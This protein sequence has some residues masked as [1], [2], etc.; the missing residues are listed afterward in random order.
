MEKAY[1]AIKSY[2]K[3]QPYKGVDETSWRDRGLTHYIWVASTDDA[4]CFSISRRRNRLAFHNFLEEASYGITTDR[5]SVYRSH[6]GPHQYCLAHILRDFQRIADRNGDEGEIGQE[7]VFH[8]RE[9]FKLSKDNPLISKWQKQRIH[10]RR[11]FIKRLLTE[12]LFYEESPH[13]VRFCQRLLDDYDR[14]WTFLS[15][16]ELECHNNRSERDL[17]SLVLWRKKSFGTQ[18][19]LGQEFVERIASVCG[20]LKKRKQ[21]LLSFISKSFRA[22]LFGEKFP[23]PVVY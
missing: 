5:Y 22:S 10:Y 17:R 15:H 9:V 20:T 11:R 7:L 13:L 2:L 18:S 12:G 1:L 3:Q 6:K 21:S 4:V 23:S 8:L 14:L 19:L 16:P